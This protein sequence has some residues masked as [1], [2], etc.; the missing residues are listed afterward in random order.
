[1]RMKRERAPFGAWLDA[2]RPERRSRPGHSDSLQAGTDCLSCVVNR[3]GYQALP[4]Q[5]S[6]KASDGK[7]P[8]GFGKR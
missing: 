2:L 4:S 5:T 3:Q 8:Y 7:D 6:A 1:V